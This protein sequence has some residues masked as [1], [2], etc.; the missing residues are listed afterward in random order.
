[1]SIRWKIAI[2]TG[3]LLLIL[4][5]M[6]TFTRYKSKHSD[7]EQYLGNIAKNIAATAAAAINGEDHLKI[8]NKVDF[9]KP[10]F[11]KIRAYL[12]KVQQ[13][14]DLKI[15]GIYTFH[16]HNAKGAKFAVMLQKK[17]YIGDYYRGTPV[18]NKMMVKVLLGQPSQTKIYTDFDKRWLSAAAPI[19]TKDG[20]IAG[21]MA[22][23]YPVDKF[24]DQLLQEIKTIIFQ[25]ILFTI[26]GVLVVILLS[27]QITSPIKELMSSVEKIES[28]NYDF[29]IKLGRR[30]ELGKLAN[31]LDKLKISVNERLLM[32]RYVSP[33]TMAMIQNSI[34]G[35]LSSEANL[36]DVV[37]LFSDMRGF[38]QFTE[39]NNPMTVVQT[40]NDL[41]SIQAEIIEKYNGSIDKFVG[42]E[43]IA[44]FT[45]DDRI[46]EALF[47]ALE[48]QKVMKIESINK[49]KLDVGIGI[50]VGSVI[51]GNIGSNKRKDYTMIGSPVNLA[52]RLCSKAL[53]HEILVCDEIH[54]KALDDENIAHVIKFKEHSK[55]LFK[56]I[57]KPVETYQ[58]L[59]KEV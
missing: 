17:T 46:N 58:A 19:K 41:F 20:K 23:D 36:Q 38:T 18:Y 3:L 2:T 1:M 35:N 49:Q 30:D 48:I 27:L 45:S 55:V 12:K 7:L 6:F 56:G 10:E 57:S 11:K 26:A 25:G 24:E 9:K 51:L 44:I 16:S 40:L 53:A 31:L 33:H 28:G 32:L 21:I 34:N 37:I 22:V 42:D 5:T 43:V 52:A 15:D 54:D 14:S 50:S 47:T 13:T 59:Y 29:T 4:V 39:E 8:R